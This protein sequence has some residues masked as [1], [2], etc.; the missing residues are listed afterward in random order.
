M[1]EKCKYKQFCFNI[2]YFAYGELKNLPDTFM[3]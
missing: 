2:D 3:S 1:N